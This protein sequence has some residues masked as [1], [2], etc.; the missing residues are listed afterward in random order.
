MLEW[1][2]GRLHLLLLVVQNSWLV[3]VLTHI[4]SLL[5]SS[6]ECEN[7][8][9]SVL[10]QVVTVLLGSELIHEANTDTASLVGSS[11]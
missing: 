4:H 2:Q 7:R 9:V 6:L 1:G 8:L 3:R 5:V 10:A 11:D